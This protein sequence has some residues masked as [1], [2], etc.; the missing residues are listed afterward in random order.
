MYIYMYTHTCVYYIYADMHTH[1]YTCTD[2][3]MCVFK[4]CIHLLS[5]HLRTS[6]GD[7]KIEP[8]EWEGC[9]GS[10]GSPKIIEVA[11]Y[12]HE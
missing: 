6:F 5:H 9:L 12:G 3:N 8:C 7:E 11:T 1:I 10:V 2:M 4:L